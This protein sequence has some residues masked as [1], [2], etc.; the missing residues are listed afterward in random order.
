MGRPLKKGLD[1]YPLDTDFLNDEKIQVLAASLQDKHNATLV[2]AGFLTVLWG[3]IY[4]RGADP[5]ILDEHT[6]LYVCR[7]MRITPKRFHEIVNLCTEL[8]I[9]MAQPWHD[10]GILV[11]RRVESTVSSFM[12]ERER[13]REYWAA[14]TGGESGGDIRKSSIYKSSNG[15][16]RGEKQSGRFHPAPSNGSRAGEA[17]VAD[18]EAM[19]RLGERGESITRDSINAEVAAMRDERNNG[20]QQD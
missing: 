12:A 10:H 18:Q 19:R 2:A 7:L 14:K 8:G 3:Q 5:F 9:F 16:S 6:T 15:K 1:Y 17:V 11:S 4:R 20:A 13:K